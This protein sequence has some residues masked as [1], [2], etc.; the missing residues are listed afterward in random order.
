MADAQAPERFAARRAFE[1]TSS[2]TEVGATHPATYTILLEAIEQF[3]AAQHL[4]DLQ[5]AARRWLMEVYRPLWEAVRARQL[6]AVF[7]GDRSA[8]L[9][10]RLVTWR[11]MQAP[12]L[13]WPTALD[14]FIETQTGTGSSSASSRNG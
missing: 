1:R 12:D 14:R 5:Q 11:R 13:D 6:T 8:D 9:I 2:L 10:A 4:D 7:P 3:R